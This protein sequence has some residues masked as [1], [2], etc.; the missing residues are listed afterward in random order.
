[1]KPN[2]HLRLGV[3]SDLDELFPIYMDKNVNRFLNFEVM[4]RQE[5]QVIF[6]ELFQS[7]QLYVY[8]Q[9]SEIVAT[10][11]VM[12]QKR[13]ASHV[14]SLGTLATNPKFFRRGIGTHFVQA[15]IEKLKVEGIKRID[16]C[17]EADNPVALSF[18][19]KMGF[20][21]EGILRKYFKRVDE[22]E[23]IDEHMLALIVD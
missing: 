4:H 23:Y 15:L 2:F 9:D 5:F 14:V 11:I 22:N 17:A 8:E 16:L 18:Y 1:M 13:R 6:N 21:Q 19:R 12:R 10:C 20:Q 7:G 3:V